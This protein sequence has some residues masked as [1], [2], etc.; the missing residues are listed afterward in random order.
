MKEV[1]S[2]RYGV[3]F[4]KAFGDV[5]VFNRFVSDLLGIKFHCDVV[6]TEKEFDTVIGGVRP[7]FD[8]YA[9]DK[10]NR[11]VVDIQHRKDCDHYDRFLHYHCV[12]LLEQVKSSENYKPP[13]AVYTIVVLTSGD[14]HKTPI[15]VIDFD[16]KD[17]QGRPLG[18]IPHKVVYLC[19]KY[20]SDSTP[21]SYREWLQVIDDSLDGH[22]DESLYHTPEV[23]RAVERIEKDDISPE[24]KY[25]MIE[26][27]NE[28]QAG[29][30]MLKAA[31][32]RIAR[33]LLAMGLGIEAVAEATGLT[34]AELAGIRE[35]GLEGG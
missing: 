12:A 27:Y 34:A 20:W 21:A 4:K 33:N 23:Q 32:A 5:D 2:L 6:E 14:K 9:E 29:Q 25:W 19:P 3:I 15:A 18:E 13:L 35:Q 16:P 10:Q 7:R 11:V 28:E 24:E 17:E 30:E 22:I 8:L 31:E 1:A 26:E